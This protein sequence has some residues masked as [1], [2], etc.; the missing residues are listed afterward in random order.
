MVVKSLLSLL[1]T[2]IAANPTIYGS[3]LLAVDFVFSCE[4]NPRKRTWAATELRPQHGFVDVGHLGQ[5]FAW[6][7]EQQCDVRVPEV[8]VFIFGFS[9][10]CLILKDGRVFVSYCML[11]YFACSLCNI[12][13]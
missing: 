4:A 7:V 11:V 8:D 12:V 6:D 3:I 9:C 5:T 2:H 10:K 1:Q 13:P